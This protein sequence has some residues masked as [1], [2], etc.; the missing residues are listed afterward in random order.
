MCQNWNET[1]G[2]PMA[3]ERRCKANDATIDNDAIIYH[4][5]TCKYKINDE[6]ISRTNDHKANAQSAE[7]T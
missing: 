1:V 3:A 4:Q 7:E 6:A 2:V 5:D